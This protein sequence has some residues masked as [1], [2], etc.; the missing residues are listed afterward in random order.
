MGLSYSFLKAEQKTWT[1]HTLE[2]DHAARSINL[3]LINRF[4]IG[5][6]VRLGYVDCSW[7]GLDYQHWLVSDG[8]H[9]LEF[10]SAGL[11]IYNA[12]VMITQQKQSFHIHM[13][14]EMDDAIQQRMKLVIGMSN[15][16][17]CLRNCE[18]V[19]NFVFRGRWDSMQMVDSNGLISYFRDYLLSD[20]ALT[21][22]NTFPS[23]IRP[24]IFNNDAKQVY[25]QEIVSNPFKATQFS[26][27]LDA[28]EDTYNILV[29]G[30]TGCGKS[31][32]INVLFNQEICRSETK[33]KSVTKDC[34]FIRGEGTITVGDRQ[35]HKKIVVADTIG[36][37]DTEWSDADTVSKIRNRVDA[38]WR[39][40]DAVLVVYRAGRLQKPHVASIKAILQW[41]HYHEK[42]NS[43]RFLF[44]GTHGEH[45]TEEEKENLRLEAI[46]MLGLRGTGRKIMSNNEII[47]SLMYVGFPPEQ[48]L[49][50]TGRIKVM[51]SWSWLRTIAS[52]AGN[53]NRLKIPQKSPTCNIL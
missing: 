15:Y 16:S 27:Y 52:L 11:D 53:T 20:K 32:L 12:R 26:Y 8:N 2:Y 45:L 50:E 9:H 17:L 31:R 23:S 35:Q 28:N 6:P 10:G 47:Q 24:H 21:L 7:G 38:S 48:S 1:D 4:V 42:K 3:P 14:T 49:N 44:V 33:H 34:Y 18:H 13:E 5:K 39:Q 36:L 25:S 19:A 43:L 37:C 29:V 22:V 40:L 30:P 41:L 51:E 46:E